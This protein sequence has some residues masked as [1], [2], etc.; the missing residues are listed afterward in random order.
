V[1]FTALTLSPTPTPKRLEAAQAAPTPSPGF[2][3]QWDELVAAAKKEG[4]VTGHFRHLLASGDAARRFKREFESRFA[5]DLRMHTAGGAR[6]NNDRL[7]AEHRAGR[8]T[9]DLFN[10]GSSHYLDTLLPA[11]V[12]QPLKPLLFHPEVLD[13]SAWWQGEFPWLDPEERYAVGYIAYPAGSETA[14]NTKLVD[15]TDIKSF[16]DLLAPKFKGKLVMRDLGPEGGQSLMFIVHLLGLDYLRQ[17]YKA[18]VITPTSREAVDRLARGEFA[19]CVWCSQTEVR[20]A[21]TQGLPVDYLTSS[22]KEGARVS[23]G[24]HTLGAVKNPPHPNAQKLFVNWFLSRDGQSVLQKVTGADSTRI[25]IPKDNVTPGEL[26]QKGVRYVFL[27]R[28]SGST[29]LLNEAQGEWKKLMRR[30]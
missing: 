17:L 30:R 14:Y 7:I 28:L 29:E 21:K 18:A 15:P 23:V 12:I 2:K 10:N 13:K 5:I 26:R 20:E 19:L 1:L 22:M 27:E 6:Q 4:V 16:H 9:L 25:D 11:G 8:N 24:G 3:Q